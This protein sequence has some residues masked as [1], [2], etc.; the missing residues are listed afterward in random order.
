[1]DS[2]YQP[3]R[4]PV[5]AKQLTRTFDTARDGAVTDGPSTPDR[6]DQLIL[7]DKA[8]AVLDQENKQGKDLRLGGEQA[9]VLAQFELAQVQNM[10]ANAVSHSGEQ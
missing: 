6:G 9:V 1:V 7:A 5:I 4:L 10:L 8:V 3:L 2:A